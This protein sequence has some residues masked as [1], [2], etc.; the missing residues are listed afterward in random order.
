LLEDLTDRALRSEFEP[1]VCLEAPEPAGVPAS[2]RRVDGR[3]VYRRHGGIR[4]ATRGQLVM[5]KRMVARARAGGA[6]RLTRTQ[7]AHTLGANPE[8]LDAALAGHAHATP[9]TRTQ[10]GLREDQAAAAMSVLTDGRRVS[11]INA[12][13]GA[14]KARVATELGRAWAAAGLGPVVG[15]T[16]S[17]SARSTLAADVPVSYDAAGFLGH[18]PGRRGARGPV[19]TGSRPLLLVDEAS[20]M[21]G[22]DLADL[23]AYADA[24]DEKL[25]LAGDTS[26]LQAGP[27]AAACPCSP[28]R[29]A[30][31]G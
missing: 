18:L 13:A 6:P 22:P 12:P 7:A 31:S 16:A 14:G 21:P 5:E 10:S 17:Q 1:V 8:Q 19:Q 23:V 4:Y 29:W 30:T 24:C 26:Q 11:A 2:L 25:I 3:S 28:A 20:T 9:G 15:I 27:M